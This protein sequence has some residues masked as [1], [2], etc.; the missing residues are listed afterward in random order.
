MSLDVLVTGAGGQLALCIKELYEE[1]N[2][3]I[4][5][6][7][8]TKSDLDITL[9][10]DIVSFLKEQN[11]QY[12][13]NCAAY[14]DVDG[15]EDNPE[16]AFLINAKSVGYLAEACN[17]NEVILIQI[18]TDY[19]FD[20]TK[21]EPYTIQD[22]PSPINVYGTSKLEGEHI[23]KKIMQQFYIIRAS[24]LYSDQGKNFLKTIIRKVQR[25]ENLSIIDSQSGSP[26]SCYDLAKFIYFIITT[27][28]LGYGL[29]HFGTKN[30]ANWF[31]FAKH[32]ASH[33]SDYDPS[34]LQ[35]VSSFQSRAQ[36]P[37][38]SVLCIKETEKKYGLIDIWEK[39]VSKVVN[40]VLS[41]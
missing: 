28:N 17:E 16:T 12:C 9:K 1:N 6:Y 33:F 39:S 10:K 26:T 22:E 13:I 34:K 20:G 40:K 2:D 27:P 36:R 11:F 25:N 18:S 29:Y 8:A 35:P 30:K 37:V 21:K 41:K 38:N 4:K 7:F 23:I 19:V 31:E 5:F 3:G 15:A 32:I 14:T 24:W